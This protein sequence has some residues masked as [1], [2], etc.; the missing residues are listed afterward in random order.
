MDHGLKQRLIGAT[1]LVSLAVIFVPMLVGEDPQRN[2]EIQLEIPKLP[3]PEQSKILPLPEQKPE[4]LVKVEI[5]PSKNKPAQIVAPVPAP[6]EVEPKQSASLQSW[7]VQVGSFSSRDNADKFSKVLQDKGF[8]A[9]VQH[10]RVD[11][12]DVFKV[13][14]G[15]EIS[16]EKADGLSQSL[17]KLPQV[18]ST[19]VTRYP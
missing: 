12:K 18:N 11:N 16:R 1:V 17:K 10:S 19:W 2:Q 8:D 6:V 9:F 4:Q 15:P 14:V 5:D 3:K 13:V 7:V